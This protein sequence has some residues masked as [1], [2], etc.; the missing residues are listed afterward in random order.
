[1]RNISKAL[2]NIRKVIQDHDA[3]FRREA[4]LAPR[5]PKPKPK[6]PD[7]NPKQQPSQESPEGEL[8]PNRFLNT[9]IGQEPVHEPT[10]QTQDTKTEIVEV[11]PQKDSRHSWLYNEVAKAIHNASGNNPNTKVVAVFVPVLQSGHEFE[12]LPVHETVELP[13]VHEEDFRNNDEDDIDIQEDPVNTEQQTE[14]P[15]QE[16]NALPEPDSDIT[17]QHDEPEPVLTDS[18]PEFSGEVPDLP[19]ELSAEPE[20]A[21]HLDELVPESTEHPDPEL[22]EA[23]STIEEVFDEH[24]AA[25]NQQP[26]D[27]PESSELDELDELDMTEDEDQALPDLDF[28]DTLED[29]DIILDETHESSEE[30]KDTNAN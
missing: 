18:E 19:E 16:D 26:E 28:P 11:I 5:E 4:G 8:D 27:L 14:Q 22:A 23:F 2:E 21:Q 12:D 20:Q 9:S 30:D 13:A 17:E 15:E 10:P 1:M 6:L 24:T 25:A 7:L 3:E 29:D